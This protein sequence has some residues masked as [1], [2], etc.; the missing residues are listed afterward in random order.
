VAM[1][2]SMMKSKGMPGRFWGEAVS[3]A[4]Y[5][6][7]RAPIKSVVGMTPYEAWYGRKPSV[8]HLRTFGC[9]T[10]V[11]TVSG[12]TSKLADRSTPMVMI[13]YEAGTKAYRAYNAVNKKVVVTRDVLFEEKK[14]WNWS[15]AE[16]VQ[17]ISDEIFHIVYTDDQVA[18]SNVGADTD[19]TS[20]G[21]DASWP[22]TQTEESA[23]TSPACM[24]AGAGK[25]GADFPS[26]DGTRTD[27]TS[28]SSSS[29]L[30]P[31]ASLGN[32]TH[33]SP[34][35]G[36]EALSSARA[37]ATHCQ[38]T[39]QGDGSGSS[40]PAA[41]PPRG[42]EWGR[43]SDGATDAWPG[44]ASPTTASSAAASSADEASPPMV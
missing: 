36:S 39:V 37:G 29:E 19:V 5:L 31:G 44:T 9:V 40:G 16:P 10:H 41:T 24:A 21:D 20:S 32:S 6:L 34:S 13:G 25:G 11:K 26:P 42:P 1:A 3:T 15:P 8:D 23:N 33:M 27:E 4:V 12:H 14:S 43:A 18:G 2:R 7:N 38:G 17:S 22:R 30:R 35:G 28:S